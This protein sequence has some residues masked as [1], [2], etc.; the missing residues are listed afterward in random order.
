M[1]VIGDNEVEN[2]EVAVRSRKGGDSKVMTIAALCERLQTE[3][4]VKML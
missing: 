1:T 3:V 4:K 2:K